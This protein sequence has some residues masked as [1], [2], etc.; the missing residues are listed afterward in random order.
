MQ[1]SLGRLAAWR[2]AGGWRESRWR[3]RSLWRRRVGSRRERWCVGAAVVG[4]GQDGKGF[5]RRTCED[6]GAPR[7]YATGASRATKR[8]RGPSVRTLELLRRSIG[9]FALGLASRRLSRWDVHKVFST[10]EQ[11]GRRR[12]RSR[13]QIAL[14]AK[15]FESLLRGTPWHSVVLPV[16]SVL[17]AFL[18]CGRH[19]LPRLSEATA[20]SSDCPG[21]SVPHTSSVLTKLAAADGRRAAR[22]AQADR[23][24]G[25]AV[26]LAG[27]RCLLLSGLSSERRM[28]V[29][30][31]MMAWTRA[32]RIGPQSMWLGRRRRRRMRDARL[33]CWSA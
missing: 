9:P 2:K 3:L 23:A 4:G 7:S 12:T 8:P 19:M 6:D 21:P 16:F 29:V 15:R 33:R 5:T 10:E 17:K 11:G 20:D 22:L 32:G 26:G 25:A 18:D 1:A 13:V 30:P 28:G 24:M 31:V 27:R 14:R